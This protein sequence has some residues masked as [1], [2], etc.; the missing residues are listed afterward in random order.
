MWFLALRHL[1]ARKRQTIFTLLGIVF[2]STAFVT[3][4]G[5]FEGFQGFLIKQ[6]LDND[7]H[8]RIS[9]REDV[10][11]EHA[12]DRAFFPDATHVFW[13]APPSGGRDNQR[14]QNPLGWYQ[15][16]KSDPRVSAYSPQLTTQVIVSRGTV[17][18]TARF[19]GSIPEMQERV[20]S[21]NSYFI[22]GQF[23]DIGVGGNRIVMGD[24][25]LQKLGAHVG[26]TVLISTGRSAPAPYKIVGNYVIGIRA[27]D[28]GTIFGSLGDVQKIN[29]SPSQVNEI[30]VRIHN[31][32]LGKSMAE[33]WSKISEEKIQSWDTLN[34]NVLSVFKIQNATRYLMI[35]TIL[36]VASFGIYNILNMVVTQKRKEIAILRSMGYERRDIIQLFLIQGIV[37]GC[38]GG[39][40][41]LIGGFSICS[42]LQTIPFAGGP[43]GK[44]SGYLNISFEPRIYIQAMLLS[45]GTAGFASFLPARAAGKMTPI[46]IIRAGAE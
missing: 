46:D 17:S 33:S 31:I 8:I 34:A 3:I 36:V 28:D 11:T 45:I 41:G 19:V 24:E 43:L 12:L 18:F 35:A 39:V 37:L 13:K 9:A 44:G 1:I 32:D 7:A 26:E 21:L 30:A 40:I 20:T 16:L 38:V 5:F 27:I 14:N 25:L 29:R 2:G 4:S 23:R 42:Y 10:L 22:Q 6:L 15:L